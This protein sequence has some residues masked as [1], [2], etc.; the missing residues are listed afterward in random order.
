MVKGSIRIG[1]QF[2]GKKQ[3]VSLGILGSFIISVLSI[4]I[5]AAPVSAASSIPYHHSLDPQKVSRGITL[6]RANSDHGIVEE[7]PSQNK[8]VKDSAKDYEQSILPNKS[9]DDSM[10]SES[11]NTATGEEHKSEGD[12]HGIIED[13][14][15]RTENVRRDNDAVLVASIFIALSTITVVAVAAFVIKKQTKKSA[16]KRNKK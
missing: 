9:E 6:A 5:S 8:N 14:V 16:K 12:R 3:L 13:S 11:E 4:Y 7:A 10:N 1:A 15:D 2:S